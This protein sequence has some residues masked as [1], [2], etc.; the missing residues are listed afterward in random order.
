MDDQLRET[1]GE[2]AET[3][4]LPTSSGCWLKGSVD[5]DDEEGVRS[6]TRS[7]PSVHATAR[8][9]PV[10]EKARA[11]DVCIELLREV[12]EVEVDEAKRSSTDFLKERR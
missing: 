10:E 1:T 5:V 11:L 4:E 2:S 7:E 8:Y 12:V 6:Q 9:L 3:D